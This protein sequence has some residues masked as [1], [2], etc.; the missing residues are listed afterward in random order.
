M[1]S[2][3]SVLTDFFFLLNSFTLCSAYVKVYGFD[4]YDVNWTT[5]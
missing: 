2:S 4:V 5:R 3:I 1:S